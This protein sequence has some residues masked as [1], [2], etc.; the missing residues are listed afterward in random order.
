MAT[1]CAPLRVRVCAQRYPRTNPP[2]GHLAHLQGKRTA[3]RLSAL[4]SSSSQARPAVMPGSYAA[5]AFS[6]FSTSRRA[7]SS[8]VRSSA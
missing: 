2:H 4:L 5:R 7:C 6:I 3:K 1:F 8:S